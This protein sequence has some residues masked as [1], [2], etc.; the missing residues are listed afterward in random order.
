MCAIPYG[1][2][3]VLVVMYLWAAFWPRSTPA[4][5]EDPFQ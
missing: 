3:A 5:S 1:V 2:S 4:K